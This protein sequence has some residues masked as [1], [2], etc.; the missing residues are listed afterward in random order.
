MKQYDVIIIGSG[1][2]GYVAAIRLAQLGKKVAIIE[3]EKIGGVCLNVGCIPS[4][5]LIHVAHTYDSMVNASV[6]GIEHTGLTLI[7]AT[8]LQRWKNDIVKKL[9]DGIMTL[10]TLHKVDIISGTA[11]FT[12]NRELIVEKNSETHFLSFS[13]AI[14]ATGSSPTPL[15]GFEFD[16]KLIGSATDSL[17]Y[18]KIPE[19]ICVIGGGYIGLEIGTLYATFGSKVTILEATKNLLPGTDPELVEVVAKGLVRRKIAV[20]KDSVATHSEKLKGK[21]EVTFRTPEK[22][23]KD[24]FDTV[25]VSIG[26]IPNTLGLGLEELGVKLDRKGFVRVNNRQETSISG[27]Y[28][29]G[30]CVGGMMLAHKASREGLVAASV[31]AGI[32]EIFD[33]W[34]IPAVVFT[35]PEIAYVGRTVEEAEEAGYTVKLARFPFQ[36]SGKAYTAGHTEGFVKFVVDSKTDL[37]LG[38]FIVGHEASNLIGEA[39]LAIEMGATAEDIARTIHPHPTLTETLMEAA[40]AVHGKAI[41]IFQKT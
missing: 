38:V 8:K 33:P 16:G 13:N 28:A 10:L 17:S 5:A 35:D 9:T 41:H 22:E 40:E 3:K 31:I 27:I 26:R 12:A 30:D 36:A 4:K 32:D 29:I 11:T 14:I 20:F 25:L 39:C 6:F 19:K 37:V 34:G 18:T 21:V 2:G 15:Q 7:N 1:P 24:T 23:E